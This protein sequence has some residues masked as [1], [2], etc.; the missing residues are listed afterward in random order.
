MSVVIKRPELP[1]GSNRD[2]DIIDFS[3]SRD[4]LLRV[5]KKNKDPSI[6]AIKGS[7]GTGKS[8][9]LN[10]LRKKTKDK[11]VHFDSWGYMNKQDL[12]EG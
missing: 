4:A 8:V 2:I 9:L 1:D 10:Y 12:W 6:T 5:I 3:K 7:Y 11:Y